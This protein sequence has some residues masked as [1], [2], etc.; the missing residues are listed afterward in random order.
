M[1]VAEAAQRLEQIE[2]ALELRHVHHAPRDDVAARRG[3]ERCEIAT[4]DLGARLDRDVGLRL[5][6]R[7]E[8]A[9][10]TPVPERRLVVVQHVRAHARRA[11][12]AARVD[13]GEPVLALEMRERFRRGHRARSQRA[14]AP[15]ARAASRSPTPTGSSS[16]SAPRAGARSRAA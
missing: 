5:V 13:A 14:P 8:P 16:R 4:E 9:L 12:G 2:R 7:D 11:P 3:P 6:D 1:L 15:T 10:G